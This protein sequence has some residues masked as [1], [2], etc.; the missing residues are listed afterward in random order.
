[1]NGVKS[2]E[3]QSLDTAYSMKGLKS[4]KIYDICV[5]SETNNRM[6]GREKK[7]GKKCYKK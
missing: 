7:N 6:V 2:V 1:M 3:H 5:Y 4:S